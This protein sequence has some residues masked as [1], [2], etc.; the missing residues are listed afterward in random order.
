V[1]RE[2]CANFIVLKSKG[3]DIILGMGWLSKVDAV[4]QCSKRSLILTSP[5]GERFEFV[6]T[7]PSAADCAVNQLKAGSIEDIRVV[8]EYPDI[9]PDDLPGMPP[10]RDIEFIID[11]LP[12]TAPIAKRPYRMSV[13][14]LEELKKQ[15][16][17]LLDK[18]YIHPSSSSW[19][20][21]VIFVEK[22]DGTQRMYVDYRAL[23]EVTIKNKY[24]S[25]NSSKAHGRAFRHPT[26]ETTI[27]V[28]SIAVA[29]P[30]SSRTAL[31][32]ED[33]SKGKPPTQTARARARSKWSKSAREG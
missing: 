4:I 29:H 13:S 5:E 1:G 20:A 8:C 12:G 21:P 33:P 16:K 28:V 9:F 24:P 3:I 18:G 7:L 32:L 31:N 27:I 6:A 10:E 25:S 19:G 2:F 23:N 15:L 26:K 30:T 14:E 22:K 17:E 11:L